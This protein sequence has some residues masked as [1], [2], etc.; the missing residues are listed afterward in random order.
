MRDDIAI[1]QFPGSNTERETFMACRRA[2]LNPVDFL[3]N[4][5]HEKL[6]NCAGYIII[7]GFSYEDRSRAGVIASLDPIINV[8]KV[9][10]EKGKPVLGI[11][12]GAQILIE[13]GLVPGVNN[14]ALCAALT[15]NKRVINGDVLGTGYYNSRANIACV[16]DTSQTAFSRCLDTSTFVRVPFAHAE[17][18][19][20][21]PDDL[22]ATLINNNQI[23][24][25]YCDN[26]GNI[27][28]E[29]PVNP[30]G[31]VY[32]AAAVCNPAGNVMAMMPHP[33]RTNNGDVIFQSMAEYIKEGVSNKIVP[34]DYEPQKYSIQ[35]YSPDPDGVELLVNMIITDNE[36]VSV[37]NAL[38]HLDVLV[39]A[40]RMTHWEIIAENK[41]S[42]LHDELI[43]SGALFNSNKEFIADNKPSDNSATFLVRQKEDMLG[44]QKQQSLTNRLRIDG[45]R[46][47][48]HGALWNISVNSGNF[49]TAIQQVLDNNILYNPFSQDCYKYGK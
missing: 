14:Y 17:G 41:T 22:L 47:I 45:I 15:D 24:F 43:E 46:E 29:F 49:D 3:W 36:A 38:A 39:S 48:R 9:E 27:I 21:I 7:G 5:A 44:K 1:V 25:R 30:N 32:S 16:V 8:I 13:S 42:L 34:L 23:P 31:S 33:E 26:N 18:R 37:Q 28:S 20:I 6:T 19:F 10:S 35:Q 2:G 4:E 11:C 12:N 40:Q